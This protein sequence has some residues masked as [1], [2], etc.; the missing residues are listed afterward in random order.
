MAPRRVH[1]KETPV[2]R[3]HPRVAPL[4]AALLMLG[5]C[6]GTMTDPGGPPPP[7]GPT[8]RVRVLHLSPD[9][10]AVDA[11]VN[12]TVKAV[13]GLSFPSGTT[14]VKAPAAAKIDLEVTASGSPASQ[15]VVSLD[16]LELDADKDYT[17]FAFGKLAELQLNALQDDTSG[18]ATNNVRLR[19]IHAADGV[20]TVNVLQLPDTGTPTPI[21]Q[22]L[23]YG[24]AATPVDLPSAAFT[25][26]LDL[27]LDGTPDLTFAVPALPK[28]S[29]INVFAVLDSG[30]APFLLAQ[31][32]GS[33]TARIDPQQAELRVL[34]LSPDAP[35]VNAYV[36]GKQPPAWPQV[37]F[38]QSTPFCTIAAGAHKLDVGTSASSPVLTVPQVSLQ[39]GKYTA[40][41]IGNASALKALLFENGASNLAAGKIRVRAIHAAP[42]VGTVDLFTLG[43]DG[44]AQPLLS[45]VPYGAVSDPLDVPAGAYTV[46]VDVNHDGNPELWFALPSLSAGTVANVYVTQD[47]MGRVFALAQLDGTMTARIDKA[48]ADIRVIHLSRN[49]PNVDVYANGAKVITDL[50]YANSTQALT[51]PA[52]TYD[53]AVTATG[54]APSTAVINASGV[55]FLPGKAYTVAAYGDLAMIKAE[56][57]EDKLTGINTA[58]DIRLSV[59]HVA[60]TVTRGDLYAVKPAGNVLLAPMLGFGDFANLPDLA[61]SSYRVGFDAESNGTIDIAFDLP[62]LAPGSFA[63]VFVATDPLGAVDLLIQTTGAGVLRVNAVP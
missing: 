2:N 22:N 58:T 32:D 46:G 14:A 43:A 18:L 29:I 30:G 59:I 52:G 34:H 62:V 53:L 50:A 60:P 36:D 8:A 4:I 57:L 38:T 48:T 26:G 19:I 20:G 45:Q 11:Y 5:A 33:T 27:N 7:D 56:V 63:N 49:A 16:G 47:A 3:K 44:N 55:R 21:A 40:V 12:K 15:A 39:G 51:V 28:G 25:A 6:S 17:V 13:S 31:L 9:A 41:A 42:A 37:S 35:A 23:R 1:P 54:A 10:P 61:S 24:T